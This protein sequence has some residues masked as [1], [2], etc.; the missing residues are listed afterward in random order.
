MASSS[1]GSKRIGSYIWDQAETI[2]RT[3]MEKLQLE[4]LRSCVDRIAR[5]VP[6]YQERLAQAGVTSASLRSLDDLT[7]LPFTEKTDLRDNYPYG[8]FAVPMT[9]VVRLH[10]SSGTTGK[11]TVVGYTRNDIALWS[12]LIA[13]CLASA[14]VTKDDIVQNAYGYGLFTGG[15]GIHYGVEALGAK[16]IPISGGNTQRQVLVM[17]DFGSTV[18]CCTPSYALV[19]AEALAQD[20]TNPDTLP[21]RVGIFGA[22]PWS[23]EM[24]REIETRLAIP[25]LNIYG[26]SEVMGPGVAME[27]SY[28]SGMHI[29]ED[30][31]IAEIID[32]D[33]GEALPHGE[34]GELVFSCVTKEALPLLRYRT[35]DRT[36]LLTEQCP[37]G[38]TSVRMD[39]ILGRT[40]DMLII[41]GVNVFP[42]QIETVLLRTSGAEPRYQAEPQYQIIVDRGSNHMDELT[43]LVETSEPTVAGNP[44]DNLN[45]TLRGTLQHRLA[46]EFQ[47]ALGISCTV[48]LVGPREIQRSEGKAVRVIDRRGN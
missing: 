21:L 34:L 20:G 27:C 31:F 26:L 7:R 35:R 15:L 5:S 43:V 38:R 40:D 45:E 17:K 29:S 1:S 23:E 42:S 41:R 32:P 30:H 10:A 3:D 47:S 11:P 33:T 13:R 18:L 6:F 44:A 8:L 16:V 22:E 2:S 12:S 19:I 4:R 28:Q 46:Q 48:R 37:C 39:R 25:A 9:D 24:R 14:G 36:R